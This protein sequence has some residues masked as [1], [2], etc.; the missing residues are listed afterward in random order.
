MT[1]GE[2]GDL[3]GRGPS[4][5][6]VDADR[7][8]QQSLAEVLRVAGVDVVGTAGDVRS[9][10]ELIGETLPSAVI[11][12]PRLP[13]LDAGRALISGVALGWPSV[14][15]VVMG[16]ADRG[17]TP[18]PDVDAYVSKSAPTEEFVSAALAACNC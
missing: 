18:L 4:V 9:A 15:V 10:L 17:E 13:D 12:D 7:R 6:V 2:Q 14:R 16:W 8:V 3:D 11:V 1:L 5:A